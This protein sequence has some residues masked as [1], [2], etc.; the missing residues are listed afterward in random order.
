MAS[1]KDSD[2]VIMES[3]E[4]VWHRSINVGFDGVE[5]PNNLPSLVVVGREAAYTPKAGDADHFLRAQ[6]TYLDRTGGDAGNAGETEDD[7]PD[8]CPDTD[9]F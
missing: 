6:A 2:G 8:A 5:L 3:V 4:W 9:G 7:Y 1:L